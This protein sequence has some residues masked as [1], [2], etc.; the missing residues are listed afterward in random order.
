MASTI[1]Y[2]VLIC[3]FSFITIT[4]P[5]NP[6]WRLLS[7]RNWINFVSMTSSFMLFYG[8]FGLF[9]GHICPHSQSY[10]NSVSLFH[11]NDIFAEIFKKKNGDLSVRQHFICV[12]RWAANSRKKLKQTKLWLICVATIC[13]SF[14]KKNWKVCDFAG[15]NVMEMYA[16]LGSGESMTSLWQFIDSFN[17]LQC[18]LRRQFAILS[19]AWIQALLHWQLTG[20]HTSR[21]VLLYLSGKVAHGNSTFVSPFKNRFC[22]S[23]AK[24]HDNANISRFIVCGASCWGVQT[25]KVFSLHDFL[26]PNRAILLCSNIVIVWS[27]VLIEKN[28]RANYCLSS[29]R[30]KSSTVHWRDWAR[31]WWMHSTN[32]C[33]LPLNMIS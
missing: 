17:F 32:P 24:C 7:F 19:L 13:G 12:V 22:F 28:Y 26:C 4:R 15:K 25:I 20:W 31:I 29:V 8:L 5:L 16:K 1:Y 10:A 18:K 33:F 23:C 2:L 27:L 21:I 3:Y 14:Q 11:W 9:H 30:Y 6:I